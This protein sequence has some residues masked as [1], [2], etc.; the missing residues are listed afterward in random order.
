MVRLNVYC[1]WAVSASFFCAA[2]L[3]AQPEPQSITEQA[4]RAPAAELDAR[5]GVAFFAHARSLALEHKLKPS[6]RASAWFPVAKAIDVGGGL[7]AVAASSNYGVWA[8]YGLGRVRL[9]DG[10]FRLNAA[11]GLGVGHNAPIIHADLKSGGPVVPSLYVGLQA[12]VPITREFDLGV[13]LVNEQIS[14]SHLGA[15]FSVRL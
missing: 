4:P 7:T 2:S 1:C 10:A 6:L 13:E 14:V 15:T 12:S 3:K 8:A 5:A 11:L 9:L